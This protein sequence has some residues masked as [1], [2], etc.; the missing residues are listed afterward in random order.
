MHVT[1]VVVSWNSA[2]D[3]PRCLDA[4]LAQDHP[5]LSIVVVDNASTDRSGAILRRYAD[6]GV[7]TL[8]NTTNRGFAGGVNDAVALTGGDAVLLC[9]PDAVPE[10]DHVRLL[11]DALAADERRG[12]VQG[13]LLRPAPSPSGAPVIDAT[14][15]RAFRTR[16]FRNRGEGETDRGQYETPGPVFG[17][18]GALALYRR[19]MLEDVALP[20]PDR[21]RPQVLAEELFAYFE[22]VD[23]DWRA[24][25]R[26]WTAWYEPRAVATH[27]RG[28]AGPR[29]TPTVEQL[30]FVN[31]LLVIVTCDDRRSLL[32]AAPAVLL[33]TALKAV[34]L[35][36]TV[37]SAF[38]GVVRQLPGGLG[39]ALRRRALVQAHATVPSADVIRRWFEPFDYRAWVGAWWRRARRVPPGA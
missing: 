32:R 23:L 13:K 37:P 25:M 31:R 4:L 28:G 6:R 17:V 22:D 2:A 38:A 39:S 24:A 33:T 21:R 11:V 12:A 26:G 19:A 15:H 18:T 1:A 34:E 7:H 8:W 5:D 29:R 35:L 14:G 10:P 20:R 36:V 3:L 16:L 9:N 27:E 30:N